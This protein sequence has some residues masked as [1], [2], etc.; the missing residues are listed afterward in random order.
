MFRK[1]YII[2]GHQECGREFIF[3]KGKINKK[4]LQRYLRY[5]KTQ[6]NLYASEY[7]VVTRKGWEMYAD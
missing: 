1:N 3:Y 5:L 6:Y 7:Y 4:E 2:I